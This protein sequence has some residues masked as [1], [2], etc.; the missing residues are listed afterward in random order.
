MNKLLVLS[1]LLLFITFS[2]FAQD[3]DFFQPD[4]IKKEI[5]AHQINTNLKIDGVMN[6]PEWKL[7][8]PSP[9]FVQVEP[10][11]GK[12]PTFETDVRVLY[13]RIYLYV[14]IFA[15]DSL[16]R[17]AIRATDFMRD[18][19]Y[20]RHDLIALSFDGFNDKRNAMSFAT[21]AYGVQRDLLSFDDLYYDIDWDGLWRVRT[22]RTDSG[23][24]AEIA[25]PWQTLR[26]PKTND[27]IQTWG[28]NI[29]R[30]RRLTNEI[31]ALSPFPR[32]FSSLRMD[33]AGLLK[34]LRP[35]SPKTNI[36]IQPYILT[37][38]DA[39]QNFDSSYQPHSTHLKVGGDLKWV[40]NP[41]AVLDLTANT[42]FA[43]ADADIQVNNVTRFS[44]FFPEKRQFFLENASLF[45]V[46]VAQAPDFSGGSMHIQPFFSRSI[47]L[48]TSGNPI[49]I[50]GGGR[51]VYRSSKLN[52]GAIIIRQS[53]SG[54][55]PATNFFVGRLSENFGN[56]NR[57]GG[58][59]SI[60]NSPI[61]TNLEA[62]VDGFFRLGES[63][64][65]N[66]IITE[67][68]TSNTNKRG[69]AGFAQYYYSTLH[70][71]IWWTE[72]I[73]T[74]D[75]DPQMGF[76]SRS[77]VVGTTPGINWY[78]RGKALPVKKILRSFEPG[79][80]PEVYFQASTGK[81]IERDLPIWPIWLNFHSGAFFGYGVTPIFQRLVAPFQPLSVTINPGDYY[82]TQQTIWTGSDPSKIVN[83]AVMYTWGS[84][85]NGNL[86]TTD[87]KL[88]FAPIPYISISGE[89]NRNRFSGVGSGKT[90]STVDLY[91]I[92]GRFAINPRIQLVGFYQKNS[93]NNS[94]NYNL[95]F[96]WEYEPLSYIYLIYNRGSTSPYQELKQTEDHV[97]AKIS[98]LKQF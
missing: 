45:G 32:V 79:I 74:K 42:D 96:S 53:D 12:N 63:H 66:T 94:Q 14:G 30:N 68:A 17:K 24:V 84:Y 78:Y 51:F 33:Y 82:Y 36:R 43:Q 93:L 37:S 27:S 26:Y 23:W 62:T 54:Y 77:D 86:A 40:V 2:L 92:Q 28:F 73:V 8:R 31:T 7:A 44:V 71:K 39:Y 97:V 47:G 18:F 5:T 95:R 98:Y 46:N 48:D 25:I 57:I 69:F 34:N 20:T 9:R 81:L 80:L 15:R 58:L 49:P 13:N 88:Q 85:F 60:K 38:Y 76:V 83:L 6:E 64:S 19:D 59:V 55:L 90:Y 1:I 3:A 41:N 72:S 11:Q 52:Y 61:G 21:N 70:Y 22:T 35:P 4:S 29:Y 87:V 50:V 89:F 67:S 91:I 75:F 65:L 16:G 10:Y 56:Q